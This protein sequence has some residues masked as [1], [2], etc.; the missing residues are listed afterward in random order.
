[1]THTSR[2]RIAAHFSN[3]GAVQYQRLGEI[4]QL[5]WQHPKGHVPG[6]EYHAPA[7]EACAVRELHAEAAGHAP[8]LTHLELARLES[9]LLSEPLGVLEEQRET[10]GVADWL[11]TAMRRASQYRRNV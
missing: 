8:Q 4:C 5:G 10:Q 7:R 6:R 1:M 3:P 11:D 2:P 9:C